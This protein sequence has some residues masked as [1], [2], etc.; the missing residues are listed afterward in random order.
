MILDSISQQLLPL[1]VTKGL[2]VLLHK[3]GARGTLNN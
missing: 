2:I 3:G 1:E